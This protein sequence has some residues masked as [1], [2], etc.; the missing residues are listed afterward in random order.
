MTDEP[1]EC[2][3]CGRPFDYLVDREGVPFW[4]HR[5]WKQ[6]QCQN[7]ASIT[8]EDK[9]IR[10]QKWDDNAFLDGRE[11]NWPAVKQKVKENQLAA[12]SH[13]DLERSLIWACLIECN[14]DVKLASAMYT[15][16]AEDEGLKD[17][18]PVTP[19]TLKAFRKKN[20]DEYFA[21][22]SSEVGIKGLLE[23]TKSAGTSDQTK[24]LVSRY[25]IDRAEGTPVARTETLTVTATFDD[26]EKARKETEAEYGHKQEP[27]VWEDAD[28]PD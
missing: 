11:N 10:K 18:K 7:T 12:R 13:N 4:G 9:A 24:Y 23:V 22:L 2:Q 16:A 28:G 6:I 20:M 14:N 17:I 25:L 21:E 19:A 27:G 1:L 8:P 26:I 5:N 15:K 3:R